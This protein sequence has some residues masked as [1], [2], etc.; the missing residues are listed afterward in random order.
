VREER[1]FPDANALVEAFGQEPTRAI[2]P[3]VVMVE[4]EEEELDEASE[5]ALDLAARVQHSLAR[6]QQTL[7]RALHFAEQENDYAQAVQILEGLPEPFRDNGLL[8]LYRG[9]QHRVQQLRTTIHRDAKECRFAGLRD[10]IDELL[11]LTPRDE[12]MRGLRATIPW[13]PGQE[14]TN[15]IGMQFVL[16]PAGRFRM[17]SPASEA[18]RHADEGPVH[19]V[20]IAHRFYLAVHPVTQAQY[21][22]LLRVNPAH[23]RNV[24]GCDCRLFPVEN[25]SW[26]EANT[27]CEQLSALPDEQ[28]C[29]RVYRLPTEA[30]W[31][32]AC[33]AGKNGKPFSFRATLSSNQ[34][35][36]DGRHP[37]GASRGDYLKRTSA[38]GSYP[39]NA[40]GLYDMHGNVWE[41]CADWYGETYYQKSPRRDPQG[42]T[43]GEARVLRGG[44]W[45][46]HGRMLRSAN[47]DWVGPTYRGFTVGFRVVLEV[48]Q[49]RDHQESDCGVASMSEGVY[50]KSKKST[51]P[52]SMS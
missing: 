30:E 8:D 37:H 1:R 48:R 47:R 45:Q 34:A 18:G 31:E 42:P 52:D 46:N 11:T 20:E 49:V 23:F 28:Q 15:S 17:G 3:A 35:N 32:Y 4:E 12:K 16:I 5:D 24:A 29:G 22:R 19:E 50:L 7:T 51:T 27:F 38:V 39:A 33:R 40:W 25:V 9:R 26:E 6:A 41:W 44:C 43:R 21:Q 36:F 13:E 10:R 14:I 2:I